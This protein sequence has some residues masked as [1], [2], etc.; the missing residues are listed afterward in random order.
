ML[1]YNILAHKELLMY[2]WLQNQRQN[3]YILLKHLNLKLKIGKYYN[4]KNQ[5]SGI[6]D[7]GVYSMF[8]NSATKYQN[9]FWPWLHFRL[10][11]KNQNLTWHDWHETK[12]VD[13]EYM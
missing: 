3:L 5:P 10:K 11:T 2:G 9:C 6:K 7:S 8:I 4:Q 13:S 1:K 12:I